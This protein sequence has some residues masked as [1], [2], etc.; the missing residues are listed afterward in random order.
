MGALQA[1]TPGWPA[2]SLKATHNQIPPACM[3]LLTIE[4]GRVAL[5]RSSPELKAWILTSMCSTSHLYT[6]L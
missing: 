1:Y 2:R 6:L 4:G 5:T 3:W